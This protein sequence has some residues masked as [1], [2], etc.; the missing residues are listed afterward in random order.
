MEAIA[1]ESAQPVPPRRLQLLEAAASLFRT[2]GYAATT[3]RELAEELGIQKATL[4]HHVRSKSALLAEICSVG[5]TQM[6]EGVA[7]AL[8]HE[9][10]PRARLRTLVHTHLATA[11]G[12]RDIYWTTV[13]EFRS[14]SESEQKNVS[15]ARTAYRRMISG[16]IVD[17]QA[18]G[19][20]RDDIEAQY[21]ALALVNMLSWTIT[22]YRPSDVLSPTDLADAYLEIFVGGARA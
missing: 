2:K 13:V 22:W 11:L 19:V 10:D 4:Y 6:H 17:A 3:T 14:L 16:V 5:L 8:E 20:L 1:P 21:L 15:E 12:M 9:T 18:A 7:A